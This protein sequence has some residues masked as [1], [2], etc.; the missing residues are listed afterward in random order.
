MCRR[1]YDEGR[2]PPCAPDGNPHTVDH[3]AAQDSEPAFSIWEANHFLRKS[4]ARGLHDRR[5]IFCPV[6][7][8]HENGELAKAV[9]PWDQQRVH[10]RYCTGFQT[11]CEH[12][13]DRVPGR[14]RGSPR[15]L[16]AATIR[17]KELQHSGTEATCGSGTGHGDGK[18]RWGR[19]F[20]KPE[21][22]NQVAWCGRRAFSSD[23]HGGD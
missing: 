23:R 20:E 9:A 16:E 11:F 18:I 1:Q 14:F 12:W 4:N 7:M 19:D 10:D 6:R 21:I 22:E 3:A 13:K 2:N 17:L 8:L 15:G 5:H